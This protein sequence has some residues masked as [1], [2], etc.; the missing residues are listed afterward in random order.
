MCAEASPTFAGEAVQQVLISQDKNTGG[1]IL[2]F[3]VFV[4]GA[5]KRKV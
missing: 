2:F 4:L 3:F 1:I 5:Q